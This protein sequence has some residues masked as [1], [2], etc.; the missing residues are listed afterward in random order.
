MY[1]LSLDFYF[2]K[3]LRKHTG[4][5]IAYEAC[6]LCLHHAAYLTESKMSPLKRK[7]GRASPG[8]E[9]GKKVKFAENGDQP[10]S[11]TGQEIIVP[12]PVSMVRT[13][14]DYLL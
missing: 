5:Q 10:P 14:N 13:N 8:G 6:T 1:S 3:G 12:A 9:K 11:T 4:H 7:R 2:E